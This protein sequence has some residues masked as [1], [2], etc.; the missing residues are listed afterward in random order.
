MK[1]PF[2]EWVYQKHFSQNVVKLFSEALISYKHSA[3][4]ASLLFSYLAFL[5][6][7]KELIIKSTKAVSIPQGRWDIIIKK[8]QNDDTWEKCVYEELINNSSPIFN[9]SDDVLNLQI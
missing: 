6:I 4:M 9:I 1:L 8:L 2:E 7:L 5:T 3:Y